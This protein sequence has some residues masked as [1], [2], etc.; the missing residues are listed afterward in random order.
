MLE[1]DFG[2][3]TRLLVT[4]QTVSSLSSKELSFY[5]PVGS[6]SSIFRR[7]NKKQNTICLLLAWCAVIYSCADGPCWWPTLSVFS[8]PAVPISLSSAHTGIVDPFR[9]CLRFIFKENLSASKMIL[10]SKVRYS[11]MLFA[12]QDDFLYTLVWSGI[13]HKIHHRS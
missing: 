7:Q 8:L 5:L 9:I 2:L 6:T 3:P 10:R 1:L 12:C 11:R 13:L 4:L